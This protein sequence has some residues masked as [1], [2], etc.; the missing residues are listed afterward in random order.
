L[1]KIAKKGVLGKLKNIIS[2]ASFRVRR[3][4]LAWRVGSYYQN[5]NLEILLHQKKILAPAR[6][7][8]KNAPV[9]SVVRVAPGVFL[10]KMGPGKYEVTRLQ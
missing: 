5:P 6:K 4:I 10:R 2:Q 3:Q 1:S 8:L 9:G 7:K